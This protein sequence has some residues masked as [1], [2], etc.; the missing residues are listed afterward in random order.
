MATEIV[1]SYP[2]PPYG[3]DTPQIWW[4]E[5]I[6]KRLG[7]IEDRLSRVE[8]EISHQQPTE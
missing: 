7:A 8:R 6:L 5:E 4:S 1:T 3:I 2:L